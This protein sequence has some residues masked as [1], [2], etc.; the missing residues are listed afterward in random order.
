[1]KKT[2]TKI[3]ALAISLAMSFGFISNLVYADQTDL[4]FKA[5]EYSKNDPAHPDSRY[6]FD[7]VVYTVNTGKDNGFSG[8]NQINTNDP[9]NGWQLG[10]FFIEGFTDVIEQNGEII[11]LKNVG[12]EIRFGYELY[13]D[14]DCLNGDE[15]LSISD[16]LNTSDSYFQTGTMDFERGALFVKKTDYQGNSDL[17]SYTDYLDSCTVDADNDIDM[18]EEGDYQIA[19]DYEI[20]DGRNLFG[21]TDVLGHSIL[22]TYTNYKYSFNFKIRNS[23][24]MA[25]P[26]DVS[27]S[28]EL[29]DGDVT[30][31]GFKLDLAKSRYLIV[32]VEFFKIVNG[33]PA[34][35]SHAIAAEGDTY[36]SEGIYE[37]TVS[38]PSTGATTSI[39]IY[40]GSSPD[41]MAFAQMNRDSI[42]GDSENA[43][44]DSQD[45]TTEPVA[46]TETVE[47]TTAWLESLDMSS[48]ELQ[49]YLEDTVYSDLVAEFD[50]EYYV[51]NVE[52]IYVSQEYI[53]NLAYNSQSN[54]YFGYTIDELNEFFGDERYVF[55]LGD[56]GQTVVEALDP[57][58]NVDIY[59]Q[60]LENV[61]VGAGVILICV[62]VS[63]VTVTAAPAVSMI[64]A[65]AAETGAEVAL[66]AGCISAASSLLTT[67]YESGNFDLA[68]DSALVAG[69]E[70]F[71]WGAILG[72]IEG[73]VAETF[74]LS[75][76]T[77]NGLT[78]NEAAR[79][80]QE[81]EWPLEFIT[82][83]HSWDEYLVYKDAM[84]DVE[85]IGDMNVLTRV[86][87]WEY[88]DGYGRTNAERV[89][90][91]LNPIGP[92]GFP[93][94]VHHI[95]QAYDS[96]YAVL[97]H[98]EH[99][100]NF[101]ILHWNSNSTADHGAAFIED[102]AEIFT[103]LLMEQAPDLYYALI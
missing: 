80:Q 90:Q 25:Y 78:M 49:E 43:D 54:V 42:T 23:N 8:S 18:Y 91:G 70:G 88:V 92:D 61:A 96:P 40:V 55:T 29:F 89:I 97:T 66:S 9:H 65:C 95:G 45:A 28:A 68:V 3:T 58:V 59:D 4:T 71:K 85:A 17:Q 5:V 52:A 41:L 72:A 62:T 39:K 79:I 94:E 33:L 99:H 19:L 15:T 48:E 74:A 100:S 84:L 30:E 10:R 21:A 32:D 56:D 22:P 83:I 67:G 27:T 50:G 35:I 46:Q 24:C 98:Y 60:M 36:D 81:T 12:D 103:Q 14:I 64:F 51:Q 57:T 87:D 102:K 75:G 2:I 34:S 73:G 76:A 44:A 6:F 77:L 31:N 26:M 7:P 47:D 82:R 20:K 86:I 53:D 38:N 63:A 11:I 101:S 13:E 93:Y 37:I 69:S 1:M 16:D